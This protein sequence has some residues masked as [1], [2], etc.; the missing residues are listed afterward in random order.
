MEPINVTMKWSYPRPLED[1][2]DNPLINSC[3][4]YYITRVIHYKNGDNKS[5]VYI[6]KT[7]RTF[8]ERFYE[9]F[10]DYEHYSKGTPFLHKHGDFEVRFGIIQ[11]LQ[12]GSNGMPANID[13]EKLLLA[14]ES[15][16]IYEM[17]K[18]GISTH[19]L[20]NVKQTNGYTTDYDIIVHNTGFRD[21]IPKTVD[22]RTHY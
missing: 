5:P 14:T 17:K 18:F 9:H 8:S 21:M 20:V 22:N 6:G 12:F 1:Y 4:L 10:Y 13:F 19:N 3:G 11:K 2:K 7:A 16:V 15:S